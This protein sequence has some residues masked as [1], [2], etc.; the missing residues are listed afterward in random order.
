MIL[1][2]VPLAVRA[3]IESHPKRY[4]GLRI[5]PSTRR[6]Y[7]E[8]SIA[9]HIVGT[10]L[11]LTQEEVDER[12]EKLHGT[13]PLDYAVG[14]RIGRTGLE[15]SYDAQLRG[16]RGLRKITRNRY[17]EVIAEDIVRPPRAGDD[18]E[19]TLHMPLQANIE[20]MLDE[21]LAGG[22]QPAAN[23]D[24]ESTEPPALIPDGASL[25]AIDIHS[26][27][28]LV[29]ASAPRFDLGENATPDAKTWKVI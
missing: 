3:E 17:R 9:P 5:M 2:D 16:L 27:A 8:S 24:A 1:E 14:D 25:V 22:Q 21:V 13:D 10:R 20:S 4:P 6:V 11:P 15:R 12:L 26:G 19:V 18:V 7:P 23:N 28:V 29:A